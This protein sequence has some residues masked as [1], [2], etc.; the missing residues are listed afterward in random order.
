MTLYPASALCN[1]SKNREFHEELIKQNILL[2]V[3]VLSKNLKVTKKKYNQNSYFI[4][5]WEK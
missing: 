2:C 1:K 3:M 5:L 4:V